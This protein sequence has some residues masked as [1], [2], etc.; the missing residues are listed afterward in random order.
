MLEGS[1]GG[2]GG[3]RRHWP[4]QTGYGLCR[5]ALATCPTITRCYP[6][7][8]PA[9]RYQLDEERELPVK[10]SVGILGLVALF[11]LAS[12]SPAQ[13]RKW[14]AVEDMQRHTCPSQHCGVVGYF[15]LRETVPVFVTVDGWSR[16]SVEKTA[17]CYDGHSIYVEKGP[18][19]CSTENGI[20]QG[21]FFEWVRSEYL[22]DSRPSEP[23]K[24]A[25]ELS[26]R[27]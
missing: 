18:D 1:L 7:V 17:G 10:W 13:S 25:S 19:E 4:N 22:A 23:V 2:P 6:G 16:V 26:G 15:F 20:K 3:A 21:D 12:Q 9:L 27:D 11:A 5:L 8:E 14:V 24:G